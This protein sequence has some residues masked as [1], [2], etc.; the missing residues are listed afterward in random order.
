MLGAIDI[1]LTETV[2]LY[3]AALLACGM[4]ATYA[5]RKGW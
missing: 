2:A 4:F 3:G 1:T 5:M